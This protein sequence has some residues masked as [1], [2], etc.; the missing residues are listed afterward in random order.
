MYCWW[1]WDV[2]W[3]THFFPLQQ[4]S[5]DE[6]E[7]RGFIYDNLKNTSLFATNE[8][9]VLDANYLC[10]HMR[11]MN[12]SQE[13]NVETRNLRVNGESHIGFFALQDIPPQTELT[14]N[15]NFS[16]GKEVVEGVPGFALSNPCK[17]KA[18]AAGAAKFDGDDDKKE[19]S[20]PQRKSK[21]QTNPKKRK[22]PP[23]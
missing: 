10:N 15:Y 6:C 9:V 17:N 22:D 19:S 8:D 1:L 5:H 21:R 14:F 11:F 12:C 13:P 7:R 2:Q 18:V 3:S 20:V 23:G 16:K 4:I